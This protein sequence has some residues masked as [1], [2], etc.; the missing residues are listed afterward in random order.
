MTVGTV[1]WML[2]GAV[3]ADLMAVVVLIFGRVL[4][5]ADC[6]GEAPWPDY[7][8]E[9][10]FDR[11]KPYTQDVRPGRREREKAFQEYLD[12]PYDS[13]KGKAAYERWRQ[14]A[15]AEARARDAELRGTSTAPSELSGAG[16]SGKVR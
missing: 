8:Q 4:R 12:A 16:L 2:D 13:P 15:R 14:M 11:M 3:A 9:I 7:A 1:Q 5:M 10:H 6:Y